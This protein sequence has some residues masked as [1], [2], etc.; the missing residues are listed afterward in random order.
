MTITVNNG[1]LKSALNRANANALP[2]ALQKLAFGDIVRSLPVCL[3]KQDPVAGTVATGNLTTVDVIKLPDDA[4]AAKILRVAVRAGGTTGEYTPA[5]PE[6]GDT[7]STTEFAITPC[8]DICVLGTD[9]VTDMDVV[10]LPEQGDVVEVELPVTT[11]VL[12]LP[13]E[14]VD[15]GV[16]LL[17]EAEVT[18]GTVTGGKRILV[19]LAGGGAGLPATTLAQLTS[20]K[21]TV[22]FN[23]ATDA[24]TK[25]R[26]KCLIGSKTDVNALLSTD[27]GIY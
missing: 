3:R 27:T 12:T 22:S 20:N 16:I 4:K 21:S 25:A 9:L 15:R 13:Q 10:Y 1:S 6:Y 17:L 23:N 26:V 2:A 11:G 19:P 7:P 5:A 8:G 18:A 14:W 24:P